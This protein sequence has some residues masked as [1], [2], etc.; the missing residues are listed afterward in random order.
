M[1]IPGILEFQLKDYDVMINIILIISNIFSPIKIGTIGHSFKRVQNDTV[2]KVFVDTIAKARKP[3][4]K[5]PEI[6][7][8]FTG[9][10]VKSIA[11]PGDIQHPLFKQYF[12]KANARETVVKKDILDKINKKPERLQRLNLKNIAE[13]NDCVLTPIPV[14]YLTHNVVNF[15]ND[16]NI[17]SYFH[18][19]TLQ[20]T[21][22]L[23]KGKR[24]LSVI[25]YRKGESLI[26]DFTPGD[27]LSYNKILSMHHIP[28][29]FIKFILDDDGRSNRRFDNLGYI[30]N[31]HIIFVMSGQG[32]YLQYTEGKSQ[33]VPQ[34]V[35]NYKIV[36]AEAFYL[37]SETQL[38]ML[39]I[40]IKSGDHQ[41]KAREKQVN[42]RKN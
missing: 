7:T 13:L 22:L 12:L 33:P 16:A 10:F 32:D 30:S 19:D 28:I 35:R 42:S 3:Y 39:P 29:A 21:Y 4:V 8:L 36:S 24:V 41:L 26:S 6:E 20:T 11:K 18:L 40:M 1:D 37:G 23:I 34:F 27:S 5:K 14:Y 17:T 25:R 2:V 9:H 15:N 31:G 38:P